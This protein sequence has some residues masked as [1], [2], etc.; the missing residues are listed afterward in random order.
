MGD[1]FQDFVNTLQ[2]NC[3]KRKIGVTPTESVVVGLVLVEAIVVPD[4]NTTDL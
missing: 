1:N 4:I 2:K 3:P